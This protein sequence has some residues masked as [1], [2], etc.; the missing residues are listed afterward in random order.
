MPDAIAA[1]QALKKQG[2]L[3]IVI[4][5]QPDV[6]NG[7]VDKAVVERMNAEM[8]RRLPIDAIKVCYHAQTEGCECRKPKPGMILSA[9]KELAVDLASSFMIGDRWSDISAGHTAG[10]RTVFIDRDYT[11][12]CAEAPDFTTDS[13]ASAAEWIIRSTT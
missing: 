7:L 12:G 9:A 10:C 13:L 1:G 3:L 11:E 8:A 2:F 6:G 5:N 4:T